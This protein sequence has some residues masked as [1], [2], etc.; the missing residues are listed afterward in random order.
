MAAYAR[1]CVNVSTHLRCT[2]PVWLRSVSQWKLE[3]KKI[4]CEIS[5]VKIVM[6]MHVCIALD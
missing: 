3:K 4:E 1:G 5:L 2:E 6:K